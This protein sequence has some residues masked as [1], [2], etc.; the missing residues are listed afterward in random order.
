MPRRRPHPFRFLYVVATFLVFPTF[1]L[2]AAAQKAGPIETW[3]CHAS[4]YRD[5]EPAFIL[6]RN[7]ADGRVWSCLTGE[8]EAQVY[9]D[10]RGMR[11]H[12]GRNLMDEPSHC[13]FVISTNSSKVGRS[14]PGA[15]KNG[16]RRDEEKVDLR[17]SCTGMMT[18]PNAGRML[19]RSCAQV[20]HECGPN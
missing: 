1:S 16:A 11:W 2:P 3:S 5:D 4:S 7:G 17:F 19:L 18:T 13:Q 20:R 12:F 9:T 14:H 15:F 6:T 8:K 10:R